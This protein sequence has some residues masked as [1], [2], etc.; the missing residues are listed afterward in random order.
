MFSPI[1]EISVE[2]GPVPVCTGSSLPVGPPM[3]KGAWGG[4]P[5]SILEVDGGAS[6]EFIVNVGASLVGVGVK[7]E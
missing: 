2:D 4:L 1:L 3:L 5:E 6:G 7:Y